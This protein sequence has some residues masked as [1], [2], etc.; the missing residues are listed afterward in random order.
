MLELLD[1][2]QNIEEL[3]RNYKKECERIFEIIKEKGEF[4]KL[5]FQK[6]LFDE[7]KE[8]EEAIFFIEEGFY[9]LYLGRKQAR[10]YSNSDFIFFDR[11]DKNIRLFSEFGSSVYKFNAKEIEKVLE[12]KKEMRNFYRLQGIDN[13]INIFLSLFKSKEEKK[14]KLKFREYKEG[15]IILKEGDAPD[16]IYELMSGDAVAISQGMEIGRIEAGEIF[17]EISFLTESARTATI[18]AIRKCNVLII[19]RCT[20]MEMIKEKPGFVISVAKNL[21]KRIKDL[22]Q[23]VVKTKWGRT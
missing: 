21:A 15:D 5:P 19:D 18:K 14:A 22:N 12:E 3:Y 11:F 23:E 2:P 16:N 6:D 9:K 13:K 7:A 20:F 8:K 10:F 17:G 4:L 1:I